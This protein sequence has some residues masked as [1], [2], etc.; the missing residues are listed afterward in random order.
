MRQDVTIADDRDLQRL[1]RE[2]ESA[3]RRARSPKE[4]EK[5]LERIVSRAPDGSEPSLFAHRHLAELQLERFP[6]RAA[7]HLRSVLHHHQHDDV[8][9]ALM[10][11]AQ[12]LLGN[13]RAAVG[14]YKRALQIAPRN[15]WYHHNLGHLLD[16]AL[17]RPLEAVSHLRS[18]HRMEPDQHEITASLAHCLARL[19]ELGEARLLADEAVRS[20]P[21]N[22]DHRALLAWIEDGA[23]QNGD[24]PPARPRSRG[25]RSSSRPRSGAAAAEPM[26]RSP[27]V[28][29]VRVLER[30]MRA[31]GFS[32][33]QVERAQALWEDFRAAFE[34][35]ITKPE[36]YAAAVEYAIAHV[37]EMAGI[38]QA[39]VARRYGVDKKTVA[40]RY[41]EIRD[42]L[43]LRRRDPRFM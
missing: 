34:V 28:A 39:D 17:S 29:V 2:A 21:R 35:R 36:I 37:D 18:A 33:K 42:G 4:I 24:P 25:R 43:E 14:A 23:P 5:L 10:G 15:P 6:W 19:G 26:P 13:Y 38:T 20:D 12:A 22:R 30:N 41:A 7:L 27:D 32:A 8:L 31:A 16:V 9:H 40:R 3:L 1:R 11:L